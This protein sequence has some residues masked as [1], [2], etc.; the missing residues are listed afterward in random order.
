MAILTQQQPHNVNIFSHPNQTKKK[1]KKSNMQ[2]TNE[3]RMFFVLFCSFQF[4]NP[5]KKYSIK[6]LRASIF[7][8]FFLLFCF[9][10]PHHLP[11]LNNS[12]I[13]CCCCSNTQNAYFLGNRF[14]F[15]CFKW[16]TLKTILSISFFFLIVNDDHDE[17]MH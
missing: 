13:F 4:S 17:N 10:F 11:P 6:K 8:T 5:S 15:A 7:V 1:K 12:R 16:K 3:I 14:L 2:I 9:V